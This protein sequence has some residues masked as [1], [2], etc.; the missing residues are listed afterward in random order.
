MTET[1]EFPVKEIV[2]AKRRSQIALVASLIV[3]AM[4]LTGLATFVG[5]QKLALNDVRSNLEE[6]CMEGAIDC[7]GNKGLPGSK[8][9]PGTGIRDIRCI[10]GRFVFTLTNGKNDTVGDCKAERGLRGPRG[11]RGEVGPRGPRGFQGERG[12]RGPRGERGPKGVKGP[13]GQVPKELID[14]LDQLP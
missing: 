1:T 9:V 6:L 4:G 11:P 3:L 12:L 2:K 10:D 8:G 13:P 14:F 7:S 5:L